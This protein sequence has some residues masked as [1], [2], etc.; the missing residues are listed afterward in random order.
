MGPGKCQPHIALSILWWHFGKLPRHKSTLGHSLTPYKVTSISGII[1]GLLLN[2]V[3]IQH[4]IKCISIWKFLCVVL[5]VVLIVS[6]NLSFLNWLT[7]VPSLACFDDASL[8]FL[9]QSRGGAKKAVLEIQQEDAAGCSPKP[10]KGIQAKIL[11]IK[12]VPV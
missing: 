8:S 11:K 6:G 7:I 5:Q 3:T 9:F 2:R 10:T 1:L 4:L 12:G